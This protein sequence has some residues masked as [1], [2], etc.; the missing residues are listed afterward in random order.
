M[1]NSGHLRVTVTPTEATVDYVR[2]NTGE[3]YSY[4]IEPN[5][6]F[7]IDLKQGWNL[8]SIPLVLE[9]NSIDYIFNNIIVITVELQLYAISKVINYYIFRN[10]V[11][12]TLLKINTIIRIIKYQIIGYLVIVAINVS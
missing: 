4:T 8:I 12:F 9:N 3:S 10:N 2:S 1:S 7:L 5:T 11:G 6:E